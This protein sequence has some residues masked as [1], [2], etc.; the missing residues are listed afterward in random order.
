MKIL[1]WKVSCSGPEPTQSILSIFWKHWQAPF[2]MI[3]LCPWS[4][5]GFDLESHQSEESFLEQPWS[6]WSWPPIPI[7]PPSLFIVILREESFRCRRLLWN[8]SS[9]DWLRGLCGRQAKSYHI[10]LC[11]KR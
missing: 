1:L 7:T 8:S 2:V 9:S 5:E 3:C 6:E 11:S 4:M 10:Q